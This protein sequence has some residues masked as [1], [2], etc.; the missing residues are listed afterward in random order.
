[1]APKPVA[2]KPVASL[3]PNPQTPAKPVSKFYDLWNPNY[4]TNYYDYMAYYERMDEDAACLRSPAAACASSSCRQG[5]R[6]S[7]IRSR[8]GGCADASQGAG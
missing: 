3:K 5:R 8:K 1:M 7:A 4:D 2:P 6:R